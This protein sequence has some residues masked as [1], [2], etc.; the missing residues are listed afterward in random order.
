MGRLHFP[1]VDEMTAEQR[2]VHDEIV[3]VMN[4][5]AMKALMLEQAGEVSTSSPQEFAEILKADFDMW[6]SV[7]KANGIHI[8]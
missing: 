3:N 5:P 8:D 6:L 7:I 1:S 2:D 4:T